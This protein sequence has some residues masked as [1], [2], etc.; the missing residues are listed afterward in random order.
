M[1]WSWVSLHSTPRRLSASLLGSSGLASLLIAIIGVFGLVSY[2]VA[3]RTREIGLRMVLGATRG[4]VLRLMMLDVARVI[5]LGL[6]TGFVCTFVALRYASH[7]LVPLPELDPLTFVTVP[8][9][10]VTAVLIAC[11]IPA[12]RAAAIDPN[13]ALRH[14]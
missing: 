2:A 11:Y 5:G 12:R 9:I 6:A 3:Q 7:A 1:V 8:A 4:D 13:V 14:L 10:L